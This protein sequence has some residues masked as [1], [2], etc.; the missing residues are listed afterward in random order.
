MSRLQQHRQ[1]EQT[2]KILLLLVV[3]V[4]LMGVFFQIGLK[5]II[6]ATV[7]INNLV[8]GNTTSQNEVPEDAA[9]SFY[10]II[11]IDEPEA[12]TSEATI[13]LSGDASEFEKVEFYLNNVKVEDATIKNGSFNEE[14]GRL[15]EGEN[16]VYILAT[17]DS[18]KIKKKSEVYTVNYINEPP[19][20]EIESPKDGDKTTNTEIQVKGKTDKGTS[21]RVNNFP[22]VVDFEGNFSTNVRLKE[23]ENTIE[24]TSTDIAGNT[25]KKEIKVTREKDE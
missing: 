14:I 11:N 4:I 7:F 22:V 1:K 10:G 17:A 16:K 23:G 9:S 8:R 19:E 2:K 6:S 21:V 13:I 5:S 20:L 24:V 3:I 12:A 15:R 25:E 18:G